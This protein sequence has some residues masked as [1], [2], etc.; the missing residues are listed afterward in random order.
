MTLGSR[1]LR[2]AL[3]AGVLFVVVAAVGSVAWATTAANDKFVACAKKKDGALR[4]VTAAK[5][6]RKTERA[7]TWNIT[8]PRGLRGPAGPDGVD[9]LDGD[10]GDD[11]D[12]GEDGFD[13]EDGVDGIDGDDA[14]LRWRYVTSSPVTTPTGN[15]VRTSA[16]CVA[17]TPHAVNGGVQLAS[18]N[19]SVRTSRPDITPGTPASPT[20]DRWSLDVVNSGAPEDITLW[21]LCAAGS[22]VP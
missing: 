11:G 19:V 2:R 15:S 12:D 8:G 5:E 10:D 3:I 17:P 7:V 16:T 4:L 21:V 18:T 22:H 13:G 14:Q 6:C 9:G 1:K 20:P